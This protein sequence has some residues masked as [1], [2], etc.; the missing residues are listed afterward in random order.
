M[1]GNVFDIQRFSIHDGPGVRV[2]V[3]LK[4]CSLRCRWCHNPEGLEPQ[5]SLR[6][7]NN[8]CIGCQMCKICPHSV[9][10]FVD[11]IHH[12]DFSKCQGCGKCVMSCPSCALI[13]YGKTM[14]DEEVANEVLK[15]KEYFNED[16]G[17]TFSGGEPLLQPDFVKATILS[18]KKKY[19]SIHVCVDTCGNVPFENIEKVIDLTDIFLFDIKCIS[20]ST[21]IYA[22]GSSN[23]L[24]LEN[25]HK[26][27][28][29]NKDIWIRV[30]IIPDIN[31]S[32]EELLKIADQINNLKNVKRVTLIPYHS[33][34]HTKYDE[35]GMEYK[36]DYRKFISDEKMEHIKELFAN[37]GIIHKS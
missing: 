21:H 30:P 17:V 7:V 4:G 29:L 33:L 19:P 1:V 23:K 32:D 35:M 9:H 31:D 25:L 26:I 34:G 20:E 3:F 2:T 18:L 37:K 13:L 22:T 24:I 11:G 10:Q 15:D 27:D 36:Y 8:L 16:G 28:E 14:S 6:F 12:I 5:P